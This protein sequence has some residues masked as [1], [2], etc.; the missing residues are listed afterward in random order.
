MVKSYPVGVFQGEVNYAPG[1]M[2]SA[3]EVNASSG[4]ITF[5]AA[6]ANGPVE[7]SVMATYP[8]GSLMGTF[9]AE[10]CANGSQY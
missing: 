7:G 1:G 2:S 9:H 4:S 10:F 3:Y 5:T 8:M 6:M